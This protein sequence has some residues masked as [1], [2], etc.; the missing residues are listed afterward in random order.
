MRYSLDTD[1]VS[2]L[3]VIDDRGNGLPVIKNVKGAA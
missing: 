2:H 1:I 3:K